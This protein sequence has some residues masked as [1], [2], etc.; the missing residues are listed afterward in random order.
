MGE[1]YHLLYGQFVEVLGSSFSFFGSFLPDLYILTGIIHTAHG[2]RGIL[3]FWLD[4]GLFIFLVVFFSVSLRSV[5]SIVPY[6]TRPWLSQSN[7]EPH[8][9]FVLPIIQAQ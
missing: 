4:W 7:Q 5:Y 2:G 9:F 3:F 8:F 1:V 6:Y